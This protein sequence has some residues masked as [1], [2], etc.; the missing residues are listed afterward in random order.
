MTEK[1]RKAKEWR[2]GSALPGHESVAKTAWM[3]EALHSRL[4]DL[5]ASKKEKDW[6]VQTGEETSLVL[7]KSCKVRGPVPVPVQS[8]SMLW[9]LK[10]KRMRFGVETGRMRNSG[11]WE[12]HLQFLSAG[13]DA[14]NFSLESRELALLL[15]KNTNNVC[16]KKIRLAMIC[17][18]GLG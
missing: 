4:E 18:Q 2:D 10:R 16:E 6:T 7:G 17:N 14:L 1:C 15:P 12:I 8:M 9:N 5:G 3:R 11:P 13:G